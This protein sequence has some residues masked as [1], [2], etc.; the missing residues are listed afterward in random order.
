MTLN[1]KLY[2]HIFESMDSN[3]SS[4]NAIRKDAADR[5]EKVCDDFAIAFAEWFLDRRYEWMFQN[6]YNKDVLNIPKPTPELLHKFKTEVY[7][8]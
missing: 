2:G 8:K 1:D 7:G 5:C 4:P 3:L 6:P